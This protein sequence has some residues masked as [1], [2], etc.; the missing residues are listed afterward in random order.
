M[1]KI[2]IKIPLVLSPLI[3]IGCNFNS[4][5]KGEMLLENRYKLTREFEGDVQVAEEDRWFKPTY[6]Y[7]YKTEK[8]D[9][10]LQYVDSLQ[11]MKFSGDYKLYVQYPGHSG[12]GWIIFDGQKLDLEFKNSYFFIFKLPTKFNPAGKQTVRTLHFQRW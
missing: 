2:L 9:M 11:P 4:S 1:R 5:L 8:Y 12:K 7:S 6:C 10:T 3:L